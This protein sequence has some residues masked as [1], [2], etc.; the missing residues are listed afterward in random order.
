MPFFLCV[1]THT[2][3]DTWRY[4]CKIGHRYIFPEHATIF[5][6]SIPGGF[7]HFTGK[8]IM[9]VSSFNVMKLLNLYIEM[10]CLRG[11]WCHF[12]SR[13]VSCRVAGPPVARTSDGPALAHSSLLY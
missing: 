7:P 12:K 13:V 8:Q 3:G 4:R 2:G 1:N 6:F 10:T 5:F 11:M 9:H